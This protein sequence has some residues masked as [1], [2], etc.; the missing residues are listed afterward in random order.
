MPR[1]RRRSSL[2]PGR[3]PLGATFTPESLHSK[4]VAVLRLLC[5]QRHLPATGR[6]PDLIARLLDS[7]THQS[8]ATPQPPFDPSPPATSISSPANTYSVPMVRGPDNAHHGQTSSPDLASVLSQLTALQAQVASLHQGDSG[9]QHTTTASVTSSTAPFSW[10]E[11]PASDP[12]PA[13]A[14]ALAGPSRTDA[15]RSHIPT[16]DLASPEAPLSSAVPSVPQRIRD[17][18]IRGEYIDLTELIPDNISF[19][20]RATLSVRSTHIHNDPLEVSVPSGTPRRAITD[21]SAWLEAWTVYC[22]VMVAHNPARSVELLGYQYLIQNAQQQFTTESVF[23]YNKAFRR[24]AAEHPHTR[25]DTI[26]ITLSTLKMMRGVRPPCPSCR[27]HHSRDRR[28][29]TS[30]APFRGGTVATAGR[31][32][33]H[34]FNRGRPCHRSPCRFRHTCAICH[35]TSHQAIHCGTPGAAKRRNDPASAPTRK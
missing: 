8:G 18:I 12:G 9:S 16:V 23:D 11:P 26:H 10:P 34:N 14:Q 32:V 33:C 22:S 20:E 27:V 28:P 1:G 2:E 30:Q 24:H 4:P 29:N 25:W 21:F 15:G 3:T 19:Q 35:S 31:E 7:Q 13:S 6:K 17:R 5:D